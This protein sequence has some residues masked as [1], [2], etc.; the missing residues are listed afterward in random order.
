MW[1]TEDEGEGEPVAL[2]ADDDEDGGLGKKELVDGLIT[3]VSRTAVIG[4]LIR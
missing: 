1:T 2:N 3:A 4:Y